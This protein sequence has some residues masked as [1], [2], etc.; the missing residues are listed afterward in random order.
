LAPGNGDV[1]FYSSG[2]A[3]G[4]NTFQ[5]GERERALLT[6]ADSS[7]YR[8]MPDRKNGKIQFNAGSIS[9]DE[10][11]VVTRLRYGLGNQ[12]FQ[13]AFGRCLA[14]KRNDELLLDTTLLG[15]P[16]PDGL[17]SRYA[18]RLFQ[19][20]GKPAT[21][22]EI[23][24]AVPPGLVFNISETTVGFYSDAL[25]C[26]GQPSSTII[27]TGA[28]QSERYFN[29]IRQAIRADLTF[30]PVESAWNDFAAELAARNSVCVHVRRGDYISSA[31]GAHL[32][33]VG[34]GYYTRAVEA[35]LMHVT[36]P[37]FYVFSDD[38]EWCEEHL[39][40]GYPQVFVRHTDTAKQHT[41]Q[42]LYLMSRC[43]HFI[44]A[45][46]SYSWWAAWLAGGLDKTVIAPQR[47]FQADGW[48]SK[49]IVPTEWTT[50]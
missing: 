32:G 29:D 44:I 27:L 17:P 40:L 13:Y 35:M 47:W 33:F 8:E 49:D 18:L 37:V 38:M 39:N 24:A 14:D 34:T 6:A 5:P 3:R 43:R 9:P 46:S 45:N 22:P 11:M 16:S 36:D 42:D 2:Q 28:W 12:L 4:Y 48:S 26:P 20:R 1:P 10:T 21:L 19:I 25:N 7:M 15:E 30:C 31:I 23:R 50:V 41:L